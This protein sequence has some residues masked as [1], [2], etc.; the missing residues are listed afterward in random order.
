MARIRKEN[1]RY[2]VISLRISEEERKHLDDILLKSHTN[3]SHFMRDAMNYF[4]AHY[5]VG[6]QN[7]KAA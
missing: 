3:V 4:T 6:D 2:N 7:K 1:P 5:E